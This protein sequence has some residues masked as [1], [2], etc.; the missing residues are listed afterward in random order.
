MNKFSFPLLRILEKI[1]SS[2]EKFPDRNAFCIN[3]EF[4]TYQQ[5]SEIVNSIQNEISKFN[6]EKNIFI[7][8][9][10][11][12]D[13]FTYASLIAIMFSG[14]AY[15]PINPDNPIERNQN[16]IEQAEIKF[17][18]S[19]KENNNFK[20]VET[21]VTSQLPKI[22]ERLKIKNISE[23]ENAYLLFTSGSTGL[24]KGVPISRKALNSFHDAF[25]SLGYKINENDKF[26]QMFDL[27]FD[28]S[29]M[30][31]LMPLSIGACVYPVPA[32]GI[33]YTSIYTVLEEH[34]ITFALMVPSIL[35]FLKP[36]FEDI[37]FEKLRYSLFCGEALYN[38]ITEG[39]SNCIPN[40]LIQNVYGPTEATIFCTTYDWKKENAEK[41]SFNGIVSIGKPMKNVN[42]IIVDESLNVLPKKEKGE[43]CLSGNQLT[44]GY[45]NSPEKNAESFFKI[46]EN[47]FYKTGDI[48]FVDYNGDFIYCG[49]KDNQVKIQGFRVELS[50]IEHHVRQFTGLTNV[51]AISKTNHFGNTEIYLFLENYKNDFEKILDYLKSKVPVYMLPSQITS[52]E[53][54]PL[55]VNGKVDRKQLTINN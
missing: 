45:L 18:L 3:N 29:I 47:V 25:F 31:Y 26:L 23:N 9:V 13:V 27:T 37:K 50:E 53:K 44:T 35:S 33:K 5:F 4:Y 15:V 30:S 38:D 14:N 32:E 48:C 41:K 20:N 51:A 6:S 1:K 54:F 34:E 11:N 55:N 10:I 12:D 22:S 43:L 42:A 46:D 39:W 52:L 16:I 21:I 36:Y 7:G 40:A 17:L 2:I 8:V 24:P 19:G 49:R 28:L